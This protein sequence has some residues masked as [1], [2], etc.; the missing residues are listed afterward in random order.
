MSD[1][2][3]FARPYAK[4]VFE[5]AQTSQRIPAWK[6][7]L[8][9]LAALVAMPDVQSLI[10][11]PQ[12]TPVIQAQ[13]IIDAGADAFDSDAANLVRLLAENR[14]LES[15]VDLAACY[16][17]LCDAAEGTVEAEVISAYPLDKAQCEALMVAL[18][19]RLGKNV[20]LSTREDPELLGGVVI[21]AG[22]L[23]IDGSL[24]GRLGQMARVMSH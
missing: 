10:R 7:A 9:T 13:I 14:R 16:E 6:K 8:E 1:L 21:H 18:K 2:I 4:A 22:D 23:V 20:N 12:I 5:L 11:N 19:K 15:A 17:S 24:K 3:T